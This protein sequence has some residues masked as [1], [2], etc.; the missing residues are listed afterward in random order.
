MLRVIAVDDTPTN[1]EILQDQ[2]HS[3]GL[4]L[5][6]A[7]DGESALALIRSAAQAGTPFQL[8]ILDRQLPDIDGLALASKIK[9]EPLIQNLPLL[10]LTSLDT[11]IQQEELHRAGLSGILTKPIRQS[12]LFDS[13]VNIMQPSIS[14]FKLATTP[15]DELISAH[16]IDSRREE[17]RLL[18]AEDNEINRLVVSEMLTNAGFQLDQVTNG[19]EAVEAVRKQCYDIVLMDCQ[20]PE[21]DGFE[22]TR[23]IRRLEQ[24]GTLSRRDRK[25]LTIVAVTANAIDGDRE[26]CL[27]MGMDDYI[28]KPI[29]RIALLR[30][31]DG[32]AQRSKPT[33]VDEKTEDASLATSHSASSSASDLIS[34]KS[35]ANTVIDL[36]ALMERCSGN[37]EFVSKMM[38]KLRDKVPT[39]FHAINRA[40]YHGDVNATKLA[41]HAIR[42]VAGNMSAIGVQLAAKTIEELILTDQFVRV[43]QSLD[44]LGGELDQL[45]ETIEQLLVEW[46]TN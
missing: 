38:H 5:E 2:L 25:P 22:A 3:W 44:A 7:A 37:R 33:A 1:L 41:A 6:T 32:I 16:A 30:L 45:L 31:L 21:M 10:M 12:R 36:D 11:D 27:A 42:G 14:S 20:M 23:E 26:K 17:I 29:N 24:S 43:P 13:I 28:T 34:P 39:D 8:A 35:R 4:A 18:L 19:C 46:N 9:S 15:M 40:W